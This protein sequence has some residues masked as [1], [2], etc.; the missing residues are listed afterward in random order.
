MRKI[1]VA[2]AK[3][4][5]GKTTTAV[6]LAH[7]LAMT[8]ATVVLVD[9]D[10]QG[11]A[12]GFLGVRPPH[13][14][15]EFVTG[16]NRKGE[17]VSKNNA[18]FPARDNLWLLAGG[19][20]LVEL[21][22]RL[23]EYP[24]D[25]RH[26]VLAS[27]LVPKGDGLDYLIFD[28]APGWDVL[29]VNVLMAADEVLC[30]VAMQAPSLEGLKVFFSYLL[31]AQK[32]NPALRL[33]YVLPTLFDRRTRHSPEVL[34]QLKKRFARQMCAPIGYNTGLSEAAARGQT[35]FELRPGAVSAEGYRLLV[36]KVMEDG[37]NQE[38]HS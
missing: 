12:A 6:T 7:G 19:M 25:Q 21:K 9:C 32:L 20:G 8:G 33:K 24:R 28:C 16:E 22:H 29:S 36:R 4:G 37:K 26:A 2:M 5:V 17:P 14:V 35:I 27:A 30:P 13:G 31:S 23:G 15:Y 3:G 10:T 34:G 11:Q 1:A 38:T 18:L